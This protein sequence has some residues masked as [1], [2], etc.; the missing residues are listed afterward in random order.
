M[1]QQFTIDWPHGWQTRDGRDVVI[2]CTDAPGL[3]PIHGR[4]DGI[5]R[6]L[7][8]IKNGKVQY[9]S[10]DT[11]YFS[12]DP[13]LDLVNRP[14]PSVSVP[15]DKLHDGTMLESFMLQ[16]AI[17][18]PVAPS[19]EPGSTRPVKWFYADEMENVK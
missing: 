16:Q 9:L 6:S 7:S 18:A 3:C 8:W 14:V 12:D 13:A 4:V 10:E 5:C 11:D 19:L 17:I 1:T 2:Y 15:V